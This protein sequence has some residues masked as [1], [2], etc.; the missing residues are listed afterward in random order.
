MWLVDRSGCFGV[1]YSRSGFRWQSNQVVIANP[2]I[3]FHALR[4][5]LQYPIA[6]LRANLATEALDGR[7]ALRHS[8]IERQLPISLGIQNTQD[9]R[10][11]ASGLSRFL[12]LCAMI[13]DKI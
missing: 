3:V 1:E 4:N 9:K 6:M 10:Y 2:E 7:P 5:A 8:V 13:S 12:S 11:E